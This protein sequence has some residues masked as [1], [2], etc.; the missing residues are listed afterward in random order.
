M[1]LDCLLLAADY[2]Y[3]EKEWVRMIGS[4]TF[5]AAFSAL[6]RLRN[7]KVLDL[8]DMA[9]LRG[10][11]WGSLVGLQSLECLKLEIM[12]EDLGAGGAV[13]GFSEFFFGT[14]DLCG[15][16]MLDGLDALDPTGKSG[17]WKFTLLMR[18]CA[19]QA[20]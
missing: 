19:L 16:L 1:S 17:T 5:D 8:R 10:D 7:L 4:G 9:L 6:S 13:S 20:A 3:A 14:Y 11:F 2:K 18:L 15:F 12:S